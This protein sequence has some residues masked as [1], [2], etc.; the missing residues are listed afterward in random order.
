MAVIAN[1]HLVGLGGGIEIKKFPKE[2]LYAQV[3]L[4]DPG[5]WEVGLK[6]PFALSQI[7][8]IEAAEFLEEGYSACLKGLSVSC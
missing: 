5:G 6:L 8:N 3:D 1:M 2:I 7:I 4:Q